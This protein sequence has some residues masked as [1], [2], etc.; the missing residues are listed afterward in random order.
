[1]KRRNNTDVLGTSILLI[2]NFYAGKRVIAWI[3]MPLVIFAVWFGWK[4][5]EQSRT[6]WMESKVKNALSQSMQSLAVSLPRIQITDNNSGEV[7]YAP[8]LN[9]QLHAFDLYGQTLINL[10]QDISVPMLK[11]TLVSMTEEYNSSDTTLKGQATVEFPLIAGIDK[12]MVVRTSIQ[13]P[14]YRNAN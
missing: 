13:V 8:D 3:L 5:Y 4:S 11:L 2:S 6:Q 1:M 12:E 9:V 14:H 7:F 10:N